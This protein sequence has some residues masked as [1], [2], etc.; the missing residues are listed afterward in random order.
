MGHYLEG[1]VQLEIPPYQRPYEWNR[2][3]WIDLWRDVSHQ[4]REQASGQKPPPHFMGPLIVE[5]ADGPGNIA[6]LSVVDGQQRLLTMFVVM[7]AVRDHDAFM[8]KQAVAPDNDLTTIRK[9]YEKPT[10]RLLVR[11]QNVE[12]ISAILEGEFVREIPE[13]LYGTPLAQAYRFFRYQLWTGAG[14]VRNPVPADP[15]TPIRKKGAPQPGSFDP[16]PTPSKGLNAFK[17]ADLHG[18]LTSGL[19][20]LEIKLEDSDEESS[21]IFETMNSKSTPLRQ[22][23]LLRNSIFVRMPKRREH[24]YRQVWQP[25]EDVL[26]AV[27]YRALRSEPEEQFLYEYVISSGR[28][29]SISK[30]ALHRAI[31]DEVISKLGYAVTD[32][33]QIEFENDFA[34]PI[35]TAAAIYPIAVGQRD[36]AR[37]A[38]RPFKCPAFLVEAIQEIMVMSGGPPVPVVLRALGDLHAKRTTVDE[39]AE[40][41]AYLQSFLVRSMLAGQPFSP[42]RSTFM[43]VML[44]IGPKDRLTPA[45]LRRALTASGWL[46]DPE[47]EL[48]VL[49]A[50]TSGYPPASYFTILRGIED[51]LNGGHGANKLAFGSGNKLYSIEHIYPQTDNIG[52]AW[53]ADLASWN[54]TRSAIDSRRYLLGNLT[55]VTGFDNKKNGRKPFGPK[56][57]IISAAAP[58]RLHDSITSQKKWTPKV[59][60]NR[61]ALLARTALEHWPGP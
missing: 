61:T 13:H 52:S 31:L 38:G 55:A 29:T 39:V 54:T 42:L 18:V 36:D 34:V 10:Q 16:W 32:K 14:S 17:T 1:D 7:S 46:S 5:T 22:F 30:E 25:I 9:K 26:G 19:R 6:K 20:L 50:D 3:R 12:A 23:D 24:F 53:E 51:E 56:S 59:I 48:A 11:R 60:D 47:V 57:G 44:N 41:L 27:S 21:V 2:P 45:R 43:Q 15:P 35:S 8:T 4:Y 28:H 33:S 37:I 58:L 40:M 49:S